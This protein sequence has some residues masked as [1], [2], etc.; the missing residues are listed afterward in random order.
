M[1]LVATEQYVKLEVEVMRERTWK[2]ISSLFCEFNNSSLCLLLHL[3]VE[4]CLP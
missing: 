3:M 1:K 2:M 4:S